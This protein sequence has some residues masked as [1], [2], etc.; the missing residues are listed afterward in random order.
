M[1]AKINQLEAKL[2]AETQNLQEK[3]QYLEEKLQ[4]GTEAHLELISNL[5]ESFSKKVDFHLKAASAMSCREL[6][7]H[8]H[9]KSGYYLVDPDERYKGQASFKVYCDFITTSPW[10]DKLEKI[11]TRIRPKQNTFEISSQSHYDF[12]SMCC[13]L[14]KNQVAGDYRLQR[15]L[16]R[17]RLSVCGLTAGRKLV[18]ISPQRFLAVGGRKQKPRT[19]NWI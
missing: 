8:G 4:N 7:E 3:T 13:T 14:S 10:I 15:V 1:S 19:V 12:G 17:M 18:K 6:Y 5:N 16:S 11:E 9:T 2:E